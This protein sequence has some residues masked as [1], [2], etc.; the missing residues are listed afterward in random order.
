LLQTPID[1][2]RKNYLW[3]ILCPYLLNIRKLSKEETTVILKDWSAK[4]DKIRR[5]DFNPQREVSSRLRSV[6]PFPPS[7]KEITKKEQPD[8]YNLLVRYEI[9]KVL[10]ISCELL[11]SLSSNSF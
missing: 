8:F 5:L 6:G 3:R 10:I 9:I 2:Y 1:D 4:C 7:S 11:F